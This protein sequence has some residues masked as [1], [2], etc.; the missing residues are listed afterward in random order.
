MLKKFLKIISCPLL[1][2]NDKEG[3][4][5][6]R[7]FSL[8][9]NTAYFYNASFS[10]SAVG[11]ALEYR[12]KLNKNLSLVC[13]LSMILLYLIFIHFKFSLGLLLVFEILWVIIIMTTRLL[14]SYYYR[15]YLLGA[16]GEF[17]VKEFVPPV[18][19]SKYNEYILFFKGKI[20]LIAIC[21]GLFFLPS[22][23]LTK[24]IQISLTPKHNGYKRAINISKLYNFIYPKKSKIYDMRAVAHFMMR[25][26][27]NSLEDYK[28][29]LD[30]SGKYFTKS[31]YTRFENLLLLQKK[32]SSSQDAVD[33][34]NE[35]IT[36]KKM[37]VLEESQ[38]LW[39][40]S[41]FKIENS[42]IDMILQDYDDLLA[43]L[44]SSDTKNN[45][46]IS[47]DR[48]YMLYLMQQYQKAIE[49]YDMLII[50]ASDNQK[51]FSKELQSLYAER[52]WAKKQL[53]DDK[54]A[55]I[56]FKSSDI[57]TEKLKEYEP[58]YVNQAFVR[59]KF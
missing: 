16:F 34:F 21:V 15:Q 6:F 40:K 53:G 33:I 37:S 31:D 9:N 8:F 19:E 56:D 48:A 7:N 49:S 1:Y 32:V 36:K 18:T 11:E 46:Y 5:V 26:Y 35:Y 38:M 30:L 45:F 44:K 51:D 20:I 14:C 2:Y 41:I 22:I 39:I 10:K 29:A 4:S 50:Y 57:P 58:S 47:C 3:N 54:G 23:L 28:M 12:F 24:L 52:G 17:G 42:I 25:D 55:E 43:S 59:E 13:I 27:D